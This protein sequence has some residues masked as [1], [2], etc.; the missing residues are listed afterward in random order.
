[1][2]AEPPLEPEFA[3]TIID[4]SELGVSGKWDLLVG[5]LA[6]NDENY[7]NYE[8]GATDKTVD[9]MDFLG[10]GLS[11][12]I[13]PNSPSQA[14][15]KAKPGLGRNQSQEILLQFEKQMGTIVFRD[16]LNCENLPVEGAAAKVTRQKPA[17]KKANCTKKP[18]PNI[19]QLNL[20]SKQSDD[21]LTEFKQIERQ[22]DNYLDEIEDYECRNIEV[23]KYIN[24][25]F[26]KQGEL[27][28][29]TQVKI[30]EMTPKSF[31]DY[32]EEEETPMVSI[33][34][35]PD[36]EKHRKMFN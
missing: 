1:M 18:K 16:K 8:G 7:C 26:Q 27:L 15:S 9:I 20:K 25:V 12:T 2:Q 23:S 28:I 33:T 17:A 21:E 31:R 10:K 34:K 11:S 29:D 13:R 19:P 36:L 32:V 5:E 35:T 4:F 14:Q 22:L 30:V 3:S 24:A 6:R